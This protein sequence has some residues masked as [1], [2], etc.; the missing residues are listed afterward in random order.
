MLAKAGY[1]VMID[2]TTKKRTE[3]LRIAGAGVVGVYHPLIDEEIVE[4]LHERRKK[5]YAWTVDEEESM[6]RMLREQVDGV[7]TSYPTLLRR[8]MQDAETDCLEQ[9]GAGFFLPAA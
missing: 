9:R 2:P 6:A 5:V 8:V 1:I 4:T 7:V 3:P